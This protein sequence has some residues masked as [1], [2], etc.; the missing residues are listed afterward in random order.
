MDTVIAKFFVGQMVHHALFGYRG[1]ILDVD[2]AY[3][4]SETWYEK[5]ALSRPPK[6]SPWYHVLQDGGQDGSGGHTYVAERN[7]EPDPSSEPIRHPDLDHHFIGMSDGAYTLR[8]AG[9]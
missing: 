5:V 7:L 6:D 2:P 3:N 4:G 9:N 1:V 8:R